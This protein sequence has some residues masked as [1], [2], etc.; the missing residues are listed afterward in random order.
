MK[1]VPPGRFSDWD[2]EVAWDYDGVVTTWADPMSLVPLLARGLE[3]LF[4]EHYGIEPDA[5][6]IEFYR[7]LYS[8]A[9]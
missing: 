6:R 4:Y 1:Q 9:S 5:K 2:G 7:L 8:L 3:D